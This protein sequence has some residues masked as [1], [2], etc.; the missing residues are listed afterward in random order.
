MTV[1]TYDPT[2]KELYDA[3]ESEGYPNSNEPK[4]MFRFFKVQVK[5]ANNIY[6]SIKLNSDGVIYAKI[7]KKDLLK[8]LDELWKDGLYEIVDL[9]IHSMWTNDR[10]DLSIMYIN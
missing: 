7:N 4:D 1:T 2:I 5:C 8:Q 9:D 10:G 6:A 3:K